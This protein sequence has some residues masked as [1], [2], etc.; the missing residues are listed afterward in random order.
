MISLDF[1]HVLLFTSHCGWKHLLTYLLP[2]TDPEDLLGNSF[3]TNPYFSLGLLAALILLV[4][5]VLVAIAVLCVCNSS[6]MQKRLSTS[7]SI[8]QHPVTLYMNT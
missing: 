1:Y 6:G 3:L 5:G 4:L 7:S 8:G 2:H